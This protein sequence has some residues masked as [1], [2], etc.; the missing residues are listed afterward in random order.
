MLM[1]EPE[2]I[3]KLFSYA[4]LIELIFLFGDFTRVEMR[5]TA[6]GCMTLCDPKLAKLFC[7]L[8]SSVSAP[9]FAEK[10]DSWRFCKVEGA[11]LGLREYLFYA[12]IELAL[13]CFSVISATLIWTGFLDLML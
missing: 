13:F 8:G 2:G 4:L 3:C 7:L 6:T 5:L 1:S 9:L 12:L 11:L 10:E